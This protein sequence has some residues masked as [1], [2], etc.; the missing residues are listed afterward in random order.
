MGGR[1][2]G[3]TPLLGRRAV[4]SPDGARIAVYARGEALVAVPLYTAAPDGSDRQPLVHWAKERYRWHRYMEPI[5]AQA[6]DEDL[7]SSRAACTAGFVV[8]APD[9]N[10]GLVQDCAT[11]LAAR[12]AL[13]GGKLVNWGSGSPLAQWEGVTVSGAP[14]RV[15]T[16]VQSALEV[17][18]PIPPV[19]GALEHLQRLYLPNN[20]FTG[21]IPPELGALRHLSILWL[22]GNRLTGPLPAELGQLTNLTILVL[23]QNDLTSAIPAELGQLRK[24]ERLQLDDNHLTGAIPAELG[25]LTNLTIL[26]LRQNDLTG[27]IPAEL[28]QRGNLERLQLSGNR[29][30]G[31]IPVDLKRVPDNDLGFLKLP[32]C[33]AGVMRAG[34]SRRHSAV[35]GRGDSPFRLPCGHNRAGVEV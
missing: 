10:P 17:A 27:A 14:P 6:R 30:T 33:E 32:D 25:Q 3:E 9:A 29:L 20:G 5:A 8:P 13:F 21:A 26:D 23:H 22:H 34:G 19:L 4:W 18:G 12:A 2:V 7:A 31:C 1:T 15:T 16:V 11:L 35:H 28:G 24:L